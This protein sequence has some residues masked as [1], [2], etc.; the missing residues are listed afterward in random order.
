MRPLYNERE[1]ERK[2]E[3]EGERKDKKKAKNKLIFNANRIRLSL[4]SYRHV[5]L[6]PKSDSRGNTRRIS[7]RRRVHVRSSAHTYT[8][9]REGTESRSP[10]VPSR[11]AFLS[12]P[13]FSCFRPAAPPRPRGPSSFCLPSRGGRGARSLSRS[14]P[15]WR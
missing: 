9:S 14:L 6:Y 7:S 10:S 3:R 1:K 8:R 11:V 4:F 5:L 2:R 15:L 12:L 13:P